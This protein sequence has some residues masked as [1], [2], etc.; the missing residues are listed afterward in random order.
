MINIL[1]LM[2]FWFK[3]VLF[4]YIC[5]SNYSIIILEF[6]IFHYP[7]RSVLNLSNERE[8]KDKS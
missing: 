8:G 3:Q 6:F 1:L 5:K 7:I 4:F 2:H